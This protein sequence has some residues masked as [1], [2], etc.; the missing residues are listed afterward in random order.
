VFRVGL[1]HDSHRFSD[2][3]SRPLVL[4][5]VVIDGQPGL[6]GDSDADV[7]LHALCR[8]LEQAI[9][10]ASFSRY[11]DAMSR[12]GIND[13]REYVKV[14]RSNVEAAGYR[15]G[16]VGITIEALR[17]RIE[18]HAPRMKDGIAALLGIANDAVGISAST[19]DG[20]TAFGRGE[21]V[22]AFVVVGLVARG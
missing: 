12:A 14:A 19:G 5:G 10:A 20:L 8:A 22:Q 18:P 17:P 6:E 16:N 11:A 3:A 1:G 2:D 4:G 21:G 15:I 9:G 7:V 13:S